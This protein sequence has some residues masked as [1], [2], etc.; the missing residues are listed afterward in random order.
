MELAR[1]SWCDYD[2]L[3]REY[4]DQVWGKPLFDQRELFRMLC[5]EGMQ[6]GLS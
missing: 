2:D 6:A 3:Y 5:L 4:H 1:C